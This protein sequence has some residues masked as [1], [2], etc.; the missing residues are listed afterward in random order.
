MHEIKAISSICNVLENRSYN[1]S[2]FFRELVRVSFLQPALVNQGTKFRQNFERVT[3]N[4]TFQS[5]F[6]AWREFGTTFV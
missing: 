1:V 2:R 3:S 4:Q 6:G 5:K